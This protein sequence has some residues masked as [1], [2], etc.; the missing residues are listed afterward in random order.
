M[1]RDLVQPAGLGR[2]LGP[3]THAFSVD[4]KSFSRLVFISGQVATDR[5]GNVVGAGDMRAQFVQV[6]ANLQTVLE[7]AGGTL[8]NIVSLR[9]FL[10]RADDLPL[11]N[12]CRREHYPRLFPDGVFP[13]NTLLIIDRLVLPELLLEIEAVAAI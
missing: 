6:Y 10:T 12:E 4:P 11:F 7:A 2:E 1:Q 3:Y 8:A 5:T 9:T 13:P